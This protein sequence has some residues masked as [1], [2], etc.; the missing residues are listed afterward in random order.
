MT[1]FTEDWKSQIRTWKR[2]MITQALRNFKKDGDLCPV[3]MFLYPEKDQKKL[4]GMV[5]SLTLA[6]QDDDGKEKASQMM[7]DVCR[8]HNA[9]ATLM[10]V[11]GW[12]IMIDKKTDL[13]NTPRPSKHPDR[14]EAVFIT[15]QTVTA[16][17][18][19]I[20]YKILRDRDKPYLVR[21]KELDK[22]DSLEGRMANQI[23]TI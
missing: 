10:I 9:V 11:E 13:D 8:K 14:M 23:E 4:Q 18:E 12:Y 1:K 15:F 20:T 21:I 17:T 3:F 2:S 19:M 5:T 22:T 6:F 7:R 16:E